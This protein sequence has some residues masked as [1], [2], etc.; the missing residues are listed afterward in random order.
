MKHCSRWEN[1]DSKAWWI[2]ALIRN[3]L[4][5]LE[6][7]KHDWSRPV[8][9]TVHCC[10][11]WD[12]IMGQHSFWFQ[13]T[14]VQIPVEEKKHLPLLFLSCDL[15]IAI[16]FIINAWLCKV[17]ISRINVAFLPLF[18]EFNFHRTLW[19]ICMQIISIIKVPIWLNL[20]ESVQLNFDV[21]VYEVDSFFYVYLCAN[22]I[23]VSYL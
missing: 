20:M 17:T 1:C 21:K 15:I 22:I 12:K 9:R 13:R 6:W 2:S 23:L 14:M 3:S 16:Y 4:T 5:I 19:T 7:K 18:L 10:W 8:S 11:V